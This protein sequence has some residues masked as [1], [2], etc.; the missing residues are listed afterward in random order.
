MTAIKAAAVQITP[1]SST[2]A[3][4]PQRC[5]EDRRAWT[6][7]R[8]VCDLLGSAGAVLP[9]YFSYVQ[10]PFEV[11]AEHQLFVQAVTEPSKRVARKANA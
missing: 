8:A 1:P 6:P 3:K 9:P 7:G 5:A 10:P 4:A 11:V 2:A